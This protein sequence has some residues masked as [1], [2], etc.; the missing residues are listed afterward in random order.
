MTV[1]SD[2]KE[3]WL[4]IS[5]AAHR[6]GVHPTTLRRWADEGQIPVMFTPGGHRRFSASGIEN[7][8]KERSRL[9]VVYG[10]EEI[11]AEQA[12]SRARSEVITH[13]E[14]TWLASFDESER[15]KKRLLGRRMMGLLLQYVSLNKGGEEIIE[16]ARRIGYEHAQNTMALGMSSKDALQATMFFRD[17]VME[18]AIDLP[19]TANIRAEANARLLRRINE[20]LNAFQLA[21]VEIYDRDVR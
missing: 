1:D 11:W 8:K 21:V 12:L 2:Q 16:E 6:L 20:L 10:L 5:D 17:T 14:R 7:L 13:R 3:T 15:E 18:A 4:T 19:E 9:R